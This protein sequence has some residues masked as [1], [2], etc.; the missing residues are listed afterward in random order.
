VVEETLE[1]KRGAIKNRHFKE[2][3]RHK[4][5]D[6]DETTKEKLNPEDSNCE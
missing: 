2:N 5:H 6:D 4:I 3:I 1:K